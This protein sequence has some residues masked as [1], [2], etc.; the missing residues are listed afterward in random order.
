MYMHIGM[1]MP[2]A[3]VQPASII[4]LRLLCP[5]AASLLIDELQQNYMPVQLLQ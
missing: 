2:T 4:T 1:L 5:V 3:A